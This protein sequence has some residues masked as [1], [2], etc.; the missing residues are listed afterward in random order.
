PALGTGP[1][2]GPPGLRRVA[3][4]LGRPARTDEPRRPAARPRRAG[5]EL[6][7][8][9]PAPPGGQARHHGLGAGEGP[10]RDPVGGALPA[11]RLVR[12]QLVA[13]TRREDRLAHLHAARPTRAGAGRGHAQ[14]RARQAERAVREVPAAEWD[15]LE[16]DPYYR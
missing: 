8:A 12:R 6:R 2:P 5:R 16:L 7:A 11:R 3:A 15:G 1:L 10:R 13:R 9:G 4:A 14:H